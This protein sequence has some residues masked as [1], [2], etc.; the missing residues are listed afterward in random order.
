MNSGDGPKIGTHVDQNNQLHTFAI[1][2]TNGQDAVNK[3]NGYNIN[4]GWIGLTSSTASGVFYFY[5]GEAPVNGESTFVVETIIVGIDGV[6]TTTTG[7]MSDIVIIAN[8]T[9][10]TLISGASAVTYKANRNLASSNSLDSATLVYKGAEGNTVTGGTSIALFG[11]N[12]GT[13]VAYP[14]DMEIPK[15]ASFAI[16]IDTQ[17]TA[18]TTS[19]YVAVVGYRRDGFNK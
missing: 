5:N 4:T 15:G 10:G 6:G 11:Q 14:F 18:G 17:T 19:V 13:R 1:S 9:G 7:D 16:T 2:R 8:P 12:A 3:G